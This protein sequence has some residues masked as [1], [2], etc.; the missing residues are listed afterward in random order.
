MLLA[1]SGF[2]PHIADENG[3]PV[4]A[5]ITALFPV[6]AEFGKALIGKIGFDAVFLKGFVG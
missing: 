4:V 5:D 6:Q 2:C 1:V 3:F